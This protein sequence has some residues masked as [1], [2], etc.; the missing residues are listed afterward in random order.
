MKSLIATIALA[1]CLYT[2]GCSSVSVC[3]CHDCR[4]K[5]CQCS[6]DGCQCPGCHKHDDCCPH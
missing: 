2:A 4:C 1:L 3:Q 6:P 5:S